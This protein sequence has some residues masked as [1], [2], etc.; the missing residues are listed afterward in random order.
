MKRKI[1]LMLIAMFLIINNMNAFAQQNIHGKIDG[2]IK[3]NENKALPYATVTLLKASDSSLVKGAIGDENGHFEFED[4]NSG[5]YIIAASSLGFTKTYTQPFSINIA[6]Q[7]I[8]LPA[9]EM[10]MNANMLKGVS[11]TAA[12]PFIEHKLDKTIVNVANSVVSAGSSAWEILQK[13]PGVTVDN[14]NNTIN[15]QGK[16]GVSIYIDGRPTYLS[17][18]QLADLLKNMNAGSIQ[19]IEIMTQPPAKY[20]AAGNAGIINI[21]TKK[22]KMVGFNG[23]VTAGF[24]QGRYSRENTGFN[25][26]YRNG[27]Y[28]LYGNYDFSHATWW[29]SN[30]IT[31]NFYDGTGKTLS[32]RTEQYSSNSSPDYNHNFKAGLDYYL[33]NKNTIGVMVNGTINPGKNYVDN[34]TWFKNSDG[35]LQTTSY[36]NNEYNNRWTNYTYDANYRGTFDSTGKELDV[37]VAYSKYDNS[38]MQSFLTD[39]YYPDGSLVPDSANV[40]NPNIRRG[41]LPSIISIQTAKVDYTLPLKKNAKLEF[42][43]KTSFV[44][45]DNNV[46]YDKFDNSKQ[47]WEYDSATNHFKYTENINAAYVSLSKEFNK[48]W[49][50]QLGLRGEQTISNGHQYTN[51]ST[52]KRNYVQLFPTAYISKQLNKDNTLNFSY[53]RRIDRPDYQDLNP[54]R[55]YLDPYTYEE[56]NP[57]LQPQ[58]TN[59]LELSY[60]YKSLL[61]A[62]ISYSNTNNVISQV[63]EQDDSLKITYQTNE[64]LSD[65]K[66]IGLNMTLS[67]PVTK[68]WMSVN[69]INVFHNIYQGE[70]LGGNLDFGSTAVIFNSTNSFTLPKDFTAE[71]SGYYNSSMLWSIFTI[72]PQYSVSAGI[73]KTFMNQKATLKLNVSDIFH[74]QSSYASV[75]YENLDVT[76]ANHWDSR[77][78]NLT[79]TYRFNRGNAKPVQHHHQSSIE[80]EE[81]RIK[82]GNN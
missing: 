23:D 38:S 75:K 42:G 20:D 36:T 30:Y 21:I 6:H 65:M 61:T 57:F 81:S 19:S 29:N 64:N 51:D 18:D 32:T 10:Q 79:F 27:K 62:G 9:V 25:M 8:H 50:L 54:F 1:T 26:N 46:Q 66:N 33:N 68:W 76:S 52:V 35:S 41:S 58:L 40:P 14:T 78:V 56:G 5:K 4:V 16:S 77:R 37:D 3:D 31:R 34:T 39:T 48:G 22:N 80:E 28:N 44:T 49:S 24:T 73:Q 13:S 15:L 82:K 17:G 11:V 71:I 47:Q 43:A 63:L 72:Q 7:Q 60:S 74:T 69:Y 53:G 12:K 55:Y 70:Y 2:Q 45:S 67:I 59:S